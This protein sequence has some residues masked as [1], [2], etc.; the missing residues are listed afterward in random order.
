MPMTAFVAREANS[1]SIAERYEVVGYEVVGY[2]V[3]VSSVGLRRSEPLRV[4]RVEFEEADL[5][6]VWWTFGGGSVVVVVVVGFRKSED[7]R[8]WLWWQVAKG[9]RLKSKVGMGFP[10]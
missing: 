3:V 10:L 9:R 2:K 6:Y 7:Y 8:W 4:E 1:G 5:A